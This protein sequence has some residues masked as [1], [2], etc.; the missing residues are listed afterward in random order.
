MH[1]RAGS[2]FLSSSKSGSKSGLASGSGRG[3]TLIELLVV[4]AVIALLIGILLPGLGQARKTARRVLCMANLQQYGVAHI[5]YWSDYKDSIASFNWKSGVRY[6][7][8]DPDL[9][10]ATGGDQYAHMNQ[11]VHILRTQADRPDIGRVTARIPHR[12][13]SHLILN[14]YLQQ[15]LPEAGMACPED[16]ALQSWQRDPYNLDPHPDPT[17]TGGAAWNKFWAY[18]SSYQLVPAAWNPDQRTSAGTTTWQYTED[19][20]L[21]FVGS[22]PLGG[23]GSWD[24]F[25]PANKVLIYSF[26][27]RHSSKT[28]I[29]HAY[30][31][32]VAPAVFFDGSVRLERTS[33]ANEG[34]QPNNPTSAA[35]TLYKY[36]GPRSYNFEPPTISGRPFDLVRGHYRWTRGGLKG[37]DF[38]AGEV[39]TGEPR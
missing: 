17:L 20:N 24:V 35:P 15:R 25:F 5:S 31:Q 16:R 21:F 12:R 9:Q 36:I 14:S 28:P 3:F 22:A 32:A 29:Y 18:A 23:R 37:V 2:G 8:A 10:F 7:Q 30:E 6:P 4:I 34:F 38:G 1:R 39:S 19:H 27:D 33:D 13:Y 26:H 11:A